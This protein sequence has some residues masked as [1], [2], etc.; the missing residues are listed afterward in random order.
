MRSWLAGLW[1]VH[2]LPNEG[3]DEGVGVRTAADE[4]TRHGDGVGRGQTDSPPVEELVVQ[5]GKGQGVALPTPA[6]MW[7]THRPSD[8]RWWKD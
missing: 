6:G 2:R 1:V 5:Q 7:T 3:Q 4:V 8:V